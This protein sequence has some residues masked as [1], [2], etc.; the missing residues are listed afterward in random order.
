MVLCVPPEK[1]AAAWCRCGDLV[2][3]AVRT[4]GDLGDVVQ[5]IE[6]TSLQLWLV[7][8]DGQPVAA[9]FTDI[10]VEDDGSRWIGVYGLNGR[11]VRQWAR[12]LAD[13][14]VE[15]A[16]EERCA[17]VLFAGRRAWGRLVPECKPLREERG[18]VIWERVA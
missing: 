18:A 2:R 14:M 16:R 3:D 1:F 17:R 13:R 9:W 8:E 7:L 4:A 6:D 11:G 12:A 5:R 10:N 15:F